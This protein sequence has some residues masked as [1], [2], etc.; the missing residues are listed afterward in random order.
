MEVYERFGE[1][2]CRAPYIGRS[3]W[4]WKAV[5]VKMDQ[6]TWGWVWFQKKYEYLKRTQ[7]SMKKQWKYLLGDGPRDQMLSVVNMGCKREKQAGI[8]YKS[9]G[10]GS[11]EALFCIKLSMSVC[12]DSPFSF[13]FTS[14]R[15]SC[16]KSVWKHSTKEKFSGPSRGVFGWKICHGP[17]GPDQY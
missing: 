5:G 13:L 12:L 6:N 2:M 8:Q 14:H 3:S 17:T 4:G 10:L 9:N 15:M 1:Q 7:S 16:F 11:L